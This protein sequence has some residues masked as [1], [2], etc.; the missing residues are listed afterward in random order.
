MDSIYLRWNSWVTLFLEMA[1][2][3][4]LIRFKPLWIGLP[5]LLFKMF[6]VSLGLPI[7]IGDSLFHNRDPSYSFD[8][9]DQPFSWELKLNAF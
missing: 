5:Q 9:E 1:F 3:W 7:F 4:T 6:N 2:T 8:L